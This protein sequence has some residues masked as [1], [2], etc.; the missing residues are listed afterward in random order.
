MAQDEKA[1][2]AKPDASE[3]ERT[4]SQQA[5]QQPSEK[6]QDEGKP[7]EGTRPGDLSSENDG[8]AEG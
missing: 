7:D 6:P 1:S 2:Q 8:G 4:I 5:K 3:V